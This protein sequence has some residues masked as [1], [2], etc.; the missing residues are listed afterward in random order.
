MGLPAPCG[1]IE[2][3]ALA[4]QLFRTAGIENG[5]AVNLAGHRERDAAGN[6]RLDDAGNDVD[7]RTLCRD[8]Q[9]D[10][11]R[12]RQLSQSANRFLDLAGAT[13]I[14]SANSSMMTMILLIGSSF[15]PM[16]LL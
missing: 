12:A 5:S 16:A 11:R 8:D 9:M 13:I 15:S 4:Q 14:K 10:A 1:C 2:H 7:R 6:I 3:V